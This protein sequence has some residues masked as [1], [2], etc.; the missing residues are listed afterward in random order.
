MRPLHSL[1]VAVVCTFLCSC[2]GSSSKTGRMSIEEFKAKLEGIK[3]QAEVMCVDCSG[4]GKAPDADGNQATCQTCKG[5]GKATTT[6]PSLEAFTEAFGEPEEK[7]ENPGDLI[8]PEY[9]HYP[10]AEGTI[11]LTVGL[12]ARPGDVERV[13]VSKIELAD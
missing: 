5:T 2:G 11:R 9:W 7:E 8:H 4:T 6:N 3:V 12:D 10:C 1:T 13:M